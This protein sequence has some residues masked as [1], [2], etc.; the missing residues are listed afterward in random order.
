VGVAGYLALIRKWAW[1]PI[2]LGVVAGGAAAF[3]SSR[4]TPIYQAT[5]TMLVRPAQTTAPVGSFGTL[6]QVVKT[7]A[8]LL[9]E[10]PL[11]QQVIDDLGLPQ[12]AD[13]L[14]PN[15]TVSQR[16]DTELLDVKVQDASPGR[17]ASIANT[18]LKD[19]IAQ[20][21][22]QE[23][24]QITAALQGLQSRIDDLG[25][26][27]TAHGREIAVLR[28]KSSLTPDQQA[29][30][31]S[32][33]QRQ[34]ADSA[35]YTTL[36][37]NLEDVRSNQLARYETLAVVD[38]ATPPSV[39]IRPHKLLNTL[40]AGA[41]AAML[42]VGL[43]FLIEYLDNTFTTEEEVRRATGVPLLGT[44]PYRKAGKGPEGELI[45][46]TQP[47]APA[48]EAY[49]ELR[50]NLLFSAVDRS[51]KTVVV[52]SAAPREGKTRTAAN[53]AVTLAQAGHRVIL[54]DA[55]FR[56]PDLHRI[57]RIVDLRG[58]SNMILDDQVRPE[59]IHDTALPTLRVICCGTPPPNPSE[60]L[61]SGRMLRITHELSG[62][63]DI[64]VFD[65]PPVNA[66]TDAVVLAAR[67]DA[68][69]LVIEAGRTSRAAVQRAQ[70][71]IHKV[72]GTIVGVVL[73]KA[74]TTGD[75]HEYGYA[76]PPAD[77][78]NR[79]GEPAAAEKPLQPAA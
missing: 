17:A 49:R 6:D 45:T 4:Q 9:T 38:P 20:V 36:V 56:R 13:Q 55:D 66:V 12:S 58:L 69:I 22:T 26:Q 24:Q 16:A 37:K 42:A 74:R 8:Q 62:L 43:A 47:R 40:L 14:Q 76:P 63:A 68:T 44:L 25:S 65:T 50:T 78:K 39:P 52:T 34:A 23:Q 31:M 77:A 53:L 70:Q 57:F 21:Q 1:L 27:I 10:R 19:F 33:E 3:L 72:G 60:L 18:L 71:T 29:Q 7:Y 51:L 59:L 54:V 73:N 11:L 41:L 32:L 46:L 79:A 64:L 67:F 75:V 28:S 48:S 35:S 15:V 5:T 61:G 2:L 30:L